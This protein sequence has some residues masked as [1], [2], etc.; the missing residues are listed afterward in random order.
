MS[1]EPVPPLPQKSNSNVKGCL[2]GCAIVAVVGIVG[3]A[4]I[5]FA[6]YKMGMETLNAFTESEPRPI[7]EVSMTEEESAAAKAKFDA[8]KEAVQSGESEQKE[9]SFTGQELNVMLRSNEES[10]TL[11][12]SVY[13]TI[14]DGEISGEVSL[15]LGELVPV[16]FL[17]GRYANGAAT[18]SVSAENG[19]LFVFIEDFRVKGEPASP[20]IQQELRKT[21]LAED[22]MS[23]PDLQKMMDNI[24]TVSVEGDKLLVTLK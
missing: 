18:F 19:R 4:L 2:I 8:F 23:D 15:N 10:A 6:V 7:P 1:Q 14:E 11:G 12:K 24:E 9:F 5:A 3:T 21:N 17:E 22:A 13:L 20:Q 16:G